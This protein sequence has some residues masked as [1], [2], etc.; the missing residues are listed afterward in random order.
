MRPSAR[1]HFGA[2]CVCIALAAVLGSGMVLAA[3][4]EPAPGATSS[5]QSI[6][7]VKPARGETVFNNAGDM[8][9]SVAVSPDLNAAAGDRIALIL[10]GRTASV[11]SA[12]QFKLTGI[13]RG[14]H[15]L[16]ARVLDSGGNVLIASGQMKFEMW[17]ASR[18]F[19]N[20]R[21]K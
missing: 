8:E 12:T 19:P 4:D 11:R 18:L 7:V 3:P 2:A 13:V 5:Y 1:L 20:R 21:G 10:D 17:Q 6:A 9:V 14:E 15:S 16:E